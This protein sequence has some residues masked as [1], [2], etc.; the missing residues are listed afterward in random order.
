MP[1]SPP[2]SP[3]PE[4]R[5]WWESTP[6]G[7]LVLLGFV[8]LGRGAP[9]P[10]ARLSAW[11]KGLPQRAQYVSGVEYVAASSGAAQPLHWQGDEVTLFFKGDEERAAVVRAFAAARVLHERMRVDLAL[12]VRLAV[13]AAWVPW[14]PESGQPVHPAIEL[15]SWLQQVA[16]ENGIVVTEDVYLVL[17]EAERRWMGLLGVVGQPGVPVYVFPGAL[18]GKGAPDIFRPGDEVRL[19]ESFRSYVNGPEVRRLRYVGFPLQKKQPPNLDV[20]D[21]FVAPDAHARVGAANLLPEAARSGTKLLGMVAQAPFLGLGRSPLPPKPFGQLF[22]E[23]RAL[24]VLGDPGSGKTTVLRWLAVAAAGGVLG[25]GEKAGVAERL[26]PLLV[27]VGRLA[28]VRKT[29]GGNCSV[30]EALARYFEDRRVGQAAELSGFLERRLEEGACLVLLDGL[31]EVAGEAREDIRKW[32]EAFAARY[33]A[34][35]YV[36]SSRQVGYAGFTLP[37]GLEVVLGPFN[38][39]QVRRY[40]TVFERAY[41]HW[42]AGVPDDIGADHESKKLLDALLGNPRL[43]GLAANPFLLS[44]LVLIHR[45]EGQLPRHR[46]LAYEVFARTLCEAWGSARRVVASDVDHRDIRYEEEALPI[47]GELALQMHRQWPAGVA[48]EGFV[49]DTLAR[50][51]QERDGVS[52]EEARKAAQEFLQRAG[53]DVQLLLERGPGQWGF[54]HLT[55]QEFFAAV[56]LHSAERFEEEAKE[57]L[58]E[59]RWEEVVRLG[60][61]YMALVQKRAEKTR[62]FIEEVLEFEQ[63]GERRYLTEV[64]RKQVPLAAL[65]AAEAGDVLRAS[66]RE[67]VAQA[68]ADWLRLMPQGVIEP[69][70]V[71]LAL[72]DFRE[73]MVG[74]FAQELRAEDWPARFKAFYFLSKLQGTEAADSLRSLERDDSPLMRLAAAKTLRAL[75]ERPDE[76]MLVEFC[77]HRDVLVRLTA[78]ALLRAVNRVKADEVWRAWLEEYGRSLTSPA[79]EQIAVLLAGD[80]PVIHVGGELQV[81]LEGLREE[82]VALSRM[83]KE[84]PDFFARW[85]KRLSGG[86]ALNAEETAEIVRSVEALAPASLLFSSGV[87]GLLF[88]GRQ[89]DLLLALSCSSSWDIRLAAMIVL[90]LLSRTAASGQVLAGTRTL[91]TAELDRLSQGLQPMLNDP[92]DWVRGIAVIALLERQGQQLLGHVRS[93]LSSPNVLVRSLAVAALAELAPAEAVEELTRTIQTSQ[94]WWERSAALSALWKLAAR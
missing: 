77:H 13:H 7:E 10:G 8:R 23:H 32:L 39:E 63:K 85:G 74:M 16:P 51:I 31:D 18:A 3:G 62:R 53:Q 72:T 92:T 40:V 88:A 91:S 37:G 29:L 1:E 11:F 59:P 22:A 84:L 46:V 87:A 33:P 43:R 19:W 15:C 27:S 82:L 73:R 5:P 44:S 36:V 47:L 80:E 56:G 21:V 70:A 57:H 12:P 49:I 38:D 9:T 94:K 67:R 42:E 52:A 78:F 28:D 75:K 30:V 41:R 76:E 24:V 17:P 90:G 69:V 81:F 14:N 20:M 50:A 89:T 61:G 34:N 60:V 2:A 64:L 83:G 68:L 4:E 66:V 25:L 93:L 54:L 71:E 35:R 48:P 86:E 26:L 6:A 55:F 58:L 79:H 65:L 45:A